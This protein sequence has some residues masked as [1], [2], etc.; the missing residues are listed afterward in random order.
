MEAHLQSKHPDCFIL[1]DDAL[2]VS[3]CS[4]ANDRNQEFYLPISLLTTNLIS[5]PVQECN[6]P[7]G[8]QFCVKKSKVSTPLSAEP[9]TARLA[10]ISSFPLFHK[11][12]SSEP[13]MLE[14]QLQSTQ[15]EIP[16]EKTLE[17]EQLYDLSKPSCIIPDCDN[18]K[19]L[20]K[21]ARNK[22]RGAGANTPDI[23]NTMLLITF[24]H[25]E[26]IDTDPSNLHICHNHWKRWYNYN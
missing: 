20:K 25:L 3:Q 12:A 21:L 22:I 17:F 19:K 4:I 6:V 16:S 1:V 7:P 11:A 5:D 10:S 18:T 23:E 15:T 24:Y 2:T 26:K 14:Q 13:D 9:G 8:P